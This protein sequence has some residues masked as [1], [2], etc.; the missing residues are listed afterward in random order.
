MAGQMHGMSQTNSALILRESENNNLLIVWFV[1]SQKAVISVLRYWKVF[2]VLI[3]LALLAVWARVSVLLMI[4]WFQAHSKTARVFINILID[5][6]QIME[7]VVKTQMHIIAIVRDMFCKRCKR[8]QPLVYAPLK[9]YD[10]AQIQSF[11]SEFVVA[12]NEYRTGPAAAQFL[13]RTLLN[14]HLCPVVRSLAPTHVGKLVDGGLGWLVYNPDPHLG[15]H[16][17]HSQLQ[18]PNINVA[19]AVANAGLMTLELLLPVMVVI[20]VLRHITTPAIRTTLV[21]HYR[22]AML[23]EWLLRVQ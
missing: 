12:S 19:A 3:L 21:V 20:L 2:A 15:V 18:L 5:C 14:D 4:P 17:C 8:P 1:T 10:D 23:P 11:L 9:H 16:S 22:L 7:D 13:L 6:F